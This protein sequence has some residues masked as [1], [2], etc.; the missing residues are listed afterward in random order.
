MTFRSRWRR[1]LDVE[2]L[3]ERIVTCCISSLAVAS[4]IA[5]LVLS[6]VAPSP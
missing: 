2:P 4:V 3:L 6:V 5:V 1:P